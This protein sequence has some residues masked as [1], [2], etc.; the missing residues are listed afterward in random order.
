VMPEVPKMGPLIRS[1]M[2]HLQQALPGNSGVT[3]P[4]PMV[5]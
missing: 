5:H 1:L 3:P 4:H 2:L